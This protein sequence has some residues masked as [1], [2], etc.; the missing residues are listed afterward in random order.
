[1]SKSPS[2][3]GNVLPIGSICTYPSLNPKQEA[4]V[5]ASVISTFP[6]VTKIEST[7]VIAEQADWYVQQ[8]Q[9]GANGVTVI[10]FKSPRKLPAPSVHIMVS[11]PTGVGLKGMVW[12]IVQLPKPSGVNLTASLVAVHCVGKFL[13]G[14]LPIGFQLR[15]PIRGS[16]LHHSRLCTVVFQ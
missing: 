6:K 12:S 9:V 14:K 5:G 10:E 7:T 11:V 15:F 4:S 2:E 1:M 13:P 16:R 3:T 8:Y